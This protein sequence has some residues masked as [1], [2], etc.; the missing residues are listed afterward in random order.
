MTTENFGYENFTPEILTET[1]EIRRKFRDL[2]MHPDAIKKLHY[3]FSDNFENLFNMITSEH[4]NDEILN[5]LL[6][7]RLGV[8]QDKFNTH[9]A[10]VGVGEVLVDTFVKPAIKKME[11]DKK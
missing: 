2:K 4:C 11:E 8:Y 1:Y 7:L 10:S 3:K 6:K 5:K 9:D